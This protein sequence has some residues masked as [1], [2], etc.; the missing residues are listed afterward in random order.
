MALESQR[1]WTSARSQ[2][3]VSPTDDNHYQTQKMKAQG[4]FAEVHEEVGQIIVAKVEAT[5]TNNLLDPD[6][7]ALHKLIAESKRTR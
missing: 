6:L 4:L 5:S 1:T 2:H 7:V 3:Y